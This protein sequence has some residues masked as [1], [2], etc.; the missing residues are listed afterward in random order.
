M[1]KWFGS[2]IAVEFRPGWQN[3]TAD[4]LSRCD[5]EGLAIQAIFMPA[6]LAYEELRAELGENP[7]AQELLAQVAAGS[8]PDGLD[9]SGWPLAVL[10]EYLHSR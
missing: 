4:A 6:F 10:W 7:A 1:S 2:D 3:A 8:A 9:H 5:K